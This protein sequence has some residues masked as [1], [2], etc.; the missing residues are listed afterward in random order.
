MPIGS[1]R[2]GVLALALLILAAGD[3]AAQAAKPAPPPAAARPPRPPAPGAVKVASVEGITEYRLANGLRVLLFPDPTKPTVT[4]N[5]TYLVGSRHENY[6]ETGMAHL[7]EH[8]L[9]KGSPNH[10][11]HQPGADRARR[12]F[13]RSTWYDRTNY[14]ET[15][16]ATDENLKWALEM[17]ADRM[18]NSFVAKKDLDTEM[19][20]VRNEFEM[21]ENDPAS[22]L[23][24]RVLSTAFLWHNYGKSTIG[25][26]ADLENVPIDRLQAFYRTYYQPD[27]AVL[28]VAGR[29]DEAKTLALI[30]QHLRSDSEADAEAS[31]RSTRSI[32]RRTASGR[33]RSSAWAT[34]RRSPPRTTCPR[35]RA[36]TSGAIDLLDR[37]PDGHAFRPAL[38]GSRRDEE[39]DVGRR[40]LHGPARPGLRDV[41]RRGPHRTSSR[42]RARGDAHG[43]STPR[44]DRRRSPRKKSTAPGRRS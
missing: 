1:P 17:E 37:D 24:E 25:A 20:V 34:C 7:L 38:Q 22:I 31:R 32:R 39:G 10:P 15:L 5:V 21:G 29:F 6:G 14:F 36:R 2:R 35:G 4:V 9:F 12:A 23:Q 33:S 18:V 27:N 28:L 26:K 16:Q 30:Q 3:L 44:R 11:Q 13:Q 8:L 19:T 40:L 43:R 41:R 42:R